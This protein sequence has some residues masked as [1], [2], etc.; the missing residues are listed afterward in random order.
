MIATK[1][2]VAESLKLAVDYARGEH[3]K[4]EHQLR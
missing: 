1:T 3:L 2:A 4:L